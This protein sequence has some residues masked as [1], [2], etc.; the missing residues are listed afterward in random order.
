MFILENENIITTVVVGLLFDYPTVRIPG[1]RQAYQPYDEG[2]REAQGGRHAAQDS[3]RI[4]H[5]TRII[6]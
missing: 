5:A 6:L 2:P 1:A 4:G 3:R